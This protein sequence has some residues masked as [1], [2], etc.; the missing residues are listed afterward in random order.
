[1]RRQAVIKH[2]LPFVGHAYSFAEAASGNGLPHVIEEEPLDPLR[3][4]NW[5]L[6]DN[7]TKC[8]CACRKRETDGQ[9]GPSR[10]FHDRF[11]LNS[12]TF[13]VR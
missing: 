2:G 12:Q 3:T 6:R 8:W 11:A 13:P 10:G 7:R 1:V 5:R 4:R 9:Q